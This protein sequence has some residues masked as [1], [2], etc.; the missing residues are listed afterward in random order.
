MYNQTNVVCFIWSSLS[1]VCSG[2]MF[3]C[4]VF[5]ILL[6]SWPVNFHH[7][8]FQDITMIGRFRFIIQDTPVIILTTH[9][10]SVHNPVFVWCVNKYWTEWSIII[11]SVTMVH[12]NT[13][14]CLPQHV[15]A[16]DSR[17]VTLFCFYHEVI[18][19]VLHYYV[20][21][22]DGRD[23]WAWCSWSV[24]SCSAEYFHDRKGL[25]NYILLKFSTFLYVFIFDKTFMFCQFTLVCISSSE[26]DP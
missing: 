20:L 4:L 25:F 3:V 13:L 16:C 18:F 2:I 6:C 19:S 12:L 9:I 1:C 10:P 8:Q 15:S 26:G 21:C 7:R 17:R 14:L 22:M 23:R 11:H 5:A 24:L